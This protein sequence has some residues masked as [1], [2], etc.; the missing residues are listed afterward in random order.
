MKKLFLLLNICIILLISISFSS[1]VSSRKYEDLK[2]KRN[3]CEEINAQLKTE[4][5]TFITNNTERIEKI[6]KLEKRIE[7]LC[8]DTATLGRSWRRL[9]RSYDKLDKIYELLL[10]KNK[11]LLA[12][13]K[14]E[15]QK[16]LTELQATQENLQKKE[17]ELK[18]LERDLNAKK[19]SLD[20]LSQKL[21][22]SQKD[23][24]EKA[25]RINELQSILNKKDSIVNEIKNKVSEALLS[26]KNKGLSI[27]QK[28][29]KVYV[30]MEESLLFA[31]GSFKVG[32]KGVEALK[33]LAKVLEDNPDINVMV[34]GH[35]DNVPYPKSG[36]IEDNWDLS[37]KRATE[38]IKILIKNS[39]IEPKRLI[40]AGRSKYVPINEANTKQARKKNRR[41]E[42]IL[43]PKLDEL[44]EII[45]TN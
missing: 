3:K 4:N 21:Y 18:Q 26:F 23:L 20:E 35:T 16:I 45:E 33:K 12:G 24:K 1:C 15:T 11:E 17:D 34:E 9:T 27:E 8:N 2:A 32:A 7:T 13:N 36:N 39:N 10:Q 42:I 28:N 25:K 37:V 14:S 19:Q 22:A 38:I 31:S 43:T 6:N 44:F 40:A 30:S 41:T 29:A 5:Q